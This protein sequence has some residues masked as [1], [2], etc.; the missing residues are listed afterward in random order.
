MRE[1]H[2]VIKL[3]SENRDDISKFAIDFLQEDF[4]LT[5]DALRQA[6]DYI[7]AHAEGVFLW[8][9]LVRLELLP[10]AGIRRAP[11]EVLQLLKSFPQDLVGFYKSMLERLE[12]RGDSDI[13]DSVKSLQLVLFSCRPL[14]LVELHDAVVFP[15]DGVSWNEGFHDFTIEEIEKR[16][17]YFG[18]TFL[19]VKDLDGSFH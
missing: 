9:H 12:D 15:D 16:I 19:E 1:G 13:R 17:I 6:A 11:G 2:H 8:V 4:R 7:I 14:A 10:S 3:E 5:D 18:G